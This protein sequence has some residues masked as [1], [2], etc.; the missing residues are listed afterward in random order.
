TFMDVK[1]Y[2]VYLHLNRIQ[3]AL[4]TSIGFQENE[5]DSKDF[6]F[7]DDETIKDLER[8]K[9]TYGDQKTK[10][11]LLTSFNQRQMKG[12]DFT[13]KFPL[14]REVLIKTLFQTAKDEDES[15]YQPMLSGYALIVDD[16][17]L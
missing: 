1:N 17:R 9:K 10:T 3:K 2:H 11:V 7:F 16:N 4:I 12:I 5:K 13:I 6:I 8:M 14:T 15:D